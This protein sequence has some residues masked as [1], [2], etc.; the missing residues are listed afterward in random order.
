MTCAPEQ[1]IVVPGA[2]VAGWAGVHVRV[3]TPGSVTVTPFRVTLPVF[4]TVIAYWIDWPTTL[5]TS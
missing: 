3:A 4:V 5:K 2:S 1:V